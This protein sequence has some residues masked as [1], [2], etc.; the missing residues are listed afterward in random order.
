MTIVKTRVMVQHQ[1]LCRLDRESPR[2]L[3]RRPGQAGPRPRQ[4]DQGLRRRHPLRLRQGPPHDALVSPGDQARAGGGKF[5]AL[6]PKP[7]HPLS[8]SGLDLITPNKREALQLAGIEPAPG[9]PFPAAAVCA[10]L[11][12]RYGSKNV[13]VT[14]GEDGMLL[15]AGA[16]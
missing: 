16:R 3:R 6:D 2:R 4:G 1:Q 5:I 8:F 10:R 14:L 12:E 15:S 11:D 9:A 13:V 7:K